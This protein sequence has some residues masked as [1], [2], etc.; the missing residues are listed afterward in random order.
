MPTN[1]PKRDA[2]TCPTEI[3]FRP[4]ASAQDGSVR[5]HE[6]AQLV[7]GHCLHVT[8]GPVIPAWV[9]EVVL[10]RKGV[11]AERQGSAWLRAVRPILTSKRSLRR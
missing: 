6:R 9:Y 8:P 11:L 1:N 7:V 3:A 2:T 5:D 10:N 4:E